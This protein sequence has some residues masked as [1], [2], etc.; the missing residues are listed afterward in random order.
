MRYR[1][2]I[3]AALFAFAW[4][5][6]KST[7]PKEEKKEPPKKETAQP[8]ETPRKEQP[9][10]A[11]KDPGIQA[12]D[13]E[14]R[15]RMEEVLKG[16][17]VGEQQE[18]AESDRYYDLALAYYD[19]GDFEKAQTYARLAVQKN[20]ENLKARE[21][22]AKVDS[23]RTGT[24]DHF[25]ARTVQ[26]E[27]VREIGVKIE[28]AQIEIFNHVRNG[29]RYYNARM[30]P[31]AIQEFEEA[32]FKIKH[33][34]YEVKEMAQLGP[35]V[36]QQLRRA[37]EAKKREEERVRDMKR[38]EAEGEGEAHEVARRRE[39][40]QK[41]AYL[42]ELAYMAFDQ[43]KFDPCMKLCD[44]ILLIDAHYTVATELK[45]DAG[46][47]RHRYEYYDFIKKK[48]D[49]W[50][51]LT[52][53]DDE[54]VIPYSQTVRFPSREEWALISKRITES[55]IKSQEGTQQEDEDI[56]AIQ[57]TLEK[58]KI[59][60]NFDAAKLDD[61]VAFI[62]DFTNLNIIIDDSIRT[63]V[64]LEKTIP[65]KVKGLVLK[66]VLKLALTQFGLDYTIDEAKVIK[67]STPDKT[68]GK[69]VVELHDVRD[70]LVKIQDFPGPKVELTS[71][72]SGGTPLTGAT[73][74]LEEPKASSV[75][76]IDDVINLI[77]ENI[78]PGSW[79]GEYT[80]EGTPNQQ[81][82]VNHTPR[83]Q[84]EIRDFLGRL[85]SY[86]GTMVAVTA[87]FV[88]A[89]DDF[90]DDVGVDIINQPPTAGTP[91]T[92]N[93]R[94]WPQSNPAGTNNVSAHLF[95]NGLLLQ[96]YGID[97][98]GAG[99]T[100]MDDPSGMRGPGFIS[101]HAHSL[102]AYDLRAQTFHSLM[103]FDPLT[104]V[105][106]DPLS[107]R[108]FDQGGLGL[109]YQWIGE[110]ALQGVLRALHKQQKATVVQAP[111]VTVFNTQ[112]SH[113]MVLTQIAY[114]RDLDPQ[115][116]TF[117]AAYDPVI[118][119][120]TQGVVLDVRAIV[121]NDRKYVTLELRPSLA[122]LQFMRNININT[123][124]NVAQQNLATANQPI[125]QLPWLI[126]Q[127]AETT[128]TI[129]DRGTLM[130]SGFKDILMNDMHSGVPFLEHIPVLSFFATRKGK[131]NERRR[132]MILVT[133]EIIDLAE[134][135]QQKY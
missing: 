58:T 40:T 50:K 51:A 69:A 28:Q 79:E 107:N 105:G 112:R 24:G 106:L 66:N 113:I 5:G 78:A 88:A 22:L 92:E 56:L 97:Y 119:T 104:G 16:K 116:S 124:N 96:N 129:P 93:G 77:K 49:N 102:E 18:I 71:P 120:L 109:Q 132:L 53:S 35:L 100:D 99:V 115:I 10:D 114:V 8:T 95:N 38:K 81:L 118:G 94:V 60:M 45:E 13:E 21:L 91:A 68:G 36:S 64:D 127:K 20:P 89:F 48:V 39:V 84:R 14:A 103:R 80:I 108:L 25:G 62:R 32:E 44:E 1:L 11:A 75:G 4:T 98:P 19:K 126:L 87:R 133:P 76:G 12:Q 31:E 41:I 67:I 90:L 86:T 134:H 70:I 57:N 42:L 135:E 15:R 128:V 30:Y 34:P 43:K 27:R 47:A 65:L 29:E 130:I 123:G 85:R 2:L 110:Q 63:T 74:T 37:R 33:I 17:T 121:S 82:L 122:E 73:F 125:V 7:P 23:M 72:S 3:A 59:D 117:A 55:F 52:D 131:A 83:T 101:N 9:K 111:R 54:A 61:I 26:D 46:K 6:C